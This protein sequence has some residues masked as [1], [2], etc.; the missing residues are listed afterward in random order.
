MGICTSC[1]ESIG[2]IAAEESIKPVT[3][4]KLPKFYKPKV[5]SK[6]DLLLTNEETK[7]YDDGVIERINTNKIGKS[8]SS[9]NFNT[10]PMRSFTSEVDPSYSP[11]GRIKHKYFPPNF[12]ANRNNHV[13]VN[14]VIHEV[15]ETV[16][17]TIHNLL[18]I[19]LPE[20]DYVYLWEQDEDVVQCRE[21]RHDF[22]AFHRK[23]HCRICGG[24]YC[25]KCCPLKEHQINENNFQKEPIRWCTGC[26]LRLTPG[27]VIK[28]MIER[29][30]N[31]GKGSVIPKR[32]PMDFVAVNHG[33]M[34]DE[35]I[36]PY[37]NFEFINKSDEYCCVKLLVADPYHSST[38][39]WE[40]PRPRYLALAPGA[41]CHA[42]FEV[43]ISLELFILVDHDQRCNQQIGV[44]K[45]F[46]TY[47]LSC[48]NKNAFLKYKG[49][50]KV[51]I[52]SGKA[53]SEKYKKIKSNGDKKRI[54]SP[55]KGKKGSSIIIGN[56]KES[57]LEMLFTSITLRM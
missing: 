47:R 12:L 23:H 1:L 29:R 36:S 26:D 8:T 43:N 40:V 7:E 15:K 33:E 55:G 16:D 32:K 28:N 9:G 51:E 27:D 52:R 48:Q 34:N 18:D 22:T 13:N 46:I 39:L 37:G 17:H 38:T 2:L 20:K 45:D 11:N 14:D 54:F 49:D 35:E 24:I 31:P 56:I 41:T 57:D 44:Y 10:L 6:D 53:L 42:I 21:C 50:G 3:Q 19:I 5:S 25:E 30:I 4:K